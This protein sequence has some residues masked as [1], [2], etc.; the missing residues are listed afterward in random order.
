MLP[1]SRSRCRAGLSQL[2]LPFPPG[3]TLVPVILCTQSS[4]NK[5]FLN[6]FSVCGGGTEEQMIPDNSTSSTGEGFTLFK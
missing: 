3:V 5:D 2:Q 4:V 6:Y 1:S